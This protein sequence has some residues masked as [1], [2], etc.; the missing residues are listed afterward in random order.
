MHVRKARFHVQAILASCDPRKAQITA[1]TRHTKRH[2]ALKEQAAERPNRLRCLAGSGQLDMAARLQLGDGNKTL[3]QIS[4]WLMCLLPL[5][6][7]S[8]PSADGAPL[9]QHAVPAS[10]RPSLVIILVLATSSCI[11]ETT[12]WLVA[13]RCCYPAA[14]AAGCTWPPCSNAIR[15]CPWQRT[16]RTV[17]LFLQSFPQRRKI[18][19]ISW[20]R[21]QC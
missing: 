4:T 5:S 20:N 12:H 6:E 2:P 15:H 17:P 16:T 19:A 11:T 7:I 1:H 14:E 8:L 3:E 18:E 21:W 10:H 9:L 13:M